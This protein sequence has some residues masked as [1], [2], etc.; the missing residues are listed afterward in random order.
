M[1]IKPADIPG[2][3]NKLSVRERWALCIAVLGLITAVAF[4]FG[5]DPALMAAEQ[6]EKDKIV[7]AQETTDAKTRLFAAEAKATAAQGGLSPDNLKKQIA[8]RKASVDATLAS[9]S[10]VSNTDVMETTKKLVKAY[11]QITLREMTLQA[12]QNIALGEGAVQIN[13]FQ[14][15]MVLSVEGGYLDLL[16]Y[17][18]DLEKALPGIRWSALMV[19]QKKDYTATVLTV[20]LSH[21]QLPADLKAK[22]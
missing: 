10:S 22:P 19:E 15:D 17:L 6:R 4:H 11:P 16:T 14:H 3:V 13:L 21:I 1:N 18:R 5:V 9:Q 7:W 2:I 12:P 20:K 8:E